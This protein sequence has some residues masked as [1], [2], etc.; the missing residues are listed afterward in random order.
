MRASKN[1]RDNLHGNVPDQSGAVLLLVDVINDLAFPDN[2]HLIEAA[3]GLSNRILRL[4]RHCARAGIPTIYVND[5]KGRWRSDVQDVVKSCKRGTRAGRKL[6]ELLTPRRDDYVVFKPKH[7]IFFGT[8]LDLILQ[9]IGA[10]TV[11]MAGLTTN[12]CVLISSA[13]IFMRGLRLIVPRDCVEALS[14]QLQNVA[15]KILNENFQAEIEPSSSLRL[16]SLKAKRR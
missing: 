11:I 7:S 10:H 12:A 16:T 14:P 13:E 1:Q 8:P 5:N 6:V 9:S 4:K 2:E 15:L 3:A